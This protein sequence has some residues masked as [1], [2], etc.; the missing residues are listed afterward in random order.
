MDSIANIADIPVTVASWNGNFS[1]L[2]LIKTYP[3]VS[4][5]R[6]TNL[7]TLSTENEIAENID[8]ECL[9]KEFADRKATKVKFYY[10]F[11]Y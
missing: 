9:I 4:Q 10:L 6:L 1:K 5:S 7:A 11:I 2:K 8:F 3:T